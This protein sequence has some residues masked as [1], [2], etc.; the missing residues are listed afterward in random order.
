ML[1][2][3]QRWLNHFNRL[4]PVSRFILKFT[5]NRLY[6]IR[7]DFASRYITGKGYEIG[8]QNSPLKCTHATQI[9][10]IDYLSKKESSQKYQIPENECV[11]VDIIA[12]ANNLDMIPQNSA[13]F[14]IS[15][16]VLE[17]SPN[18]IQAMLGW[19]RILQPGGILFLTLPNYL[20]NEFDFEKLPTP[21]THLA[22]DYQ[23]A[24]NNEDISTEH[25]HEHIKIIDGVD[26]NNS[27][28]F[29]QRCCELAQSNLH[30]HYHVFNKENSFDLLDFIHQKTPILV[31]NFLSF[32]NGFELLFII[33]KCDPEFLGSLTIN[34]DQPFNSSVIL[35]NVVELI[36][37][38]IFSK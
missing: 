30:T 10:Y 2:R 32:S 26:P 6:N 28:I 17:H 9:K 13:A 36:F 34:K 33:K 3:T 25:I 8:A 18:P 19:L 11:H 7:K 21:I 29:K 35:K 4:S 31:L 5:I 23:K 27:T 16:H 24:K 1:T 38:K 22:E 14:I 20:S 15:N 12:D 37:N